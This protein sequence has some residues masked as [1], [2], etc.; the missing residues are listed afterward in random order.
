MRN[1]MKSICSE[2][3][4]VMESTHISNSSKYKTTLILDSLHP[5]RKEYTRE[6]PKIKIQAGF[7]TS[8]VLGQ[9]QPRTRVNSPWFDFHLPQNV[10]HHLLLF[11]PRV[12]LLLDC[13]NTTITTFSSSSGNIF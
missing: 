4:Q 9:P 7:K 6:E 2:L 10:I 8:G 1:N 3:K 11:W 13:S 12:S 5:L